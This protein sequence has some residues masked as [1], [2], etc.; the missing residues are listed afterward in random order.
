MEGSLFLLLFLH[1]R[2]HRLIHNQTDRKIQRSS[3]NK[4]ITLTAYCSKDDF[5]N[6]IF[7]R[8]TISFQSVSICVICG[9][10]L[11]QLS[12]CFFDT[13]DSLYDI[14]IACSITHT[15]TFRSTERG[16]T[17]TSHVSFFK[18]VHCQII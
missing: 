18:Q 4:K 10:L 7:F 5:I 2:L 6:L 12:Q 13:T 15:D 14:F 17:Y 1:H 16:T 11:F 3:L 9:E 8:Q